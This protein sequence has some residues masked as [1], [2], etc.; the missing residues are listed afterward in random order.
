MKKL[1]PF[2]LIGRTVCVRLILPG[3]NKTFYNDDGNITMSLK[4][5]MLSPPRFS[6][7]FPREINIPS[8][9]KT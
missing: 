3:D 6:I 1:F 8:F 2:I 7:C 9:S 4:L 5:P